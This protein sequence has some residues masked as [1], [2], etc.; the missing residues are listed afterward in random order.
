M[1]VVRYGSLADPAVIEQLRL[2]NER[3]K[4]WTV[5]I[6]QANGNQRTPEQN[7]LYHR[8]LRKLAQQ[9]GRDTQYW[10]QFL[11][12][13]FLGY[14]D[15]QTEE[16]YTVQVLCQTSTLTVEEFTEFLNACLA[17]AADKQVF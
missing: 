9:L 13:K 8:V 15:V 2:A 4:S 11:V 6:I 17:F 10:R 5:Y 14:E 7:K 12:E 16:G 1:T 3:P